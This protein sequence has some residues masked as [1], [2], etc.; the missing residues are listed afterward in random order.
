MDAVLR[1]VTVYAFLLI[2]FRLAGR[3][4]LSEINTFDF[5]LLLIVGEATQ[6]ALLGDDFSV[7]NAFIVIGV[8]IGIDIL[9][10]LIKARSQLVAKLV[11]GVPMVLV[12]NGVPLKDRM[13]RARVDVSDVLE[14][15]RELQGL[16]RLDQIKFAILEVSG[17]ITIVPQSGEPR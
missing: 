12:E 1:A 11:E 2:L 6:Q 4:S 7:I 9:L 10:A 8:L 5:V 13:R 16:E 17:R 14:A 3:R 15:G